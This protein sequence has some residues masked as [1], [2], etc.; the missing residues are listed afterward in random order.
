M[1]HLDPKTRA[2]DQPAEPTR[3]DKIASFMPEINLGLLLVSLGG[4]ALAA[5]VFNLHL[6]LQPLFTDSTSRTMHAF[7]TLWGH[8]APHLAAIG[9]VW[10]PLPTLVQIPMVIWKPLALTGLSG[11]LQSALSAAATATMLEALLRELK[12]GAALRWSLVIGYM[13]HPMVLLYAVNGMSESML[14]LTLVSSCFFLMR[15]AQHRR[16]WDLLLLSAAG[17]TAVLTRY[18]GLAIVAATA[19][20]IFV[21]SAHSRWPTM[22]IRVEGELLT[23]LAMP[24]YAVL[25]WLLFNGIIEGDPLYFFHSQYSAMAQGVYAPE[26]LRQLAHDP[27]LTT[28][29]VGWRVLLMA[30]MYLPVSALV[31]ILA[32]RRRDTLAP[33]LTLLPLSVLAFEWGA[34]YQGGQFGWFRFF[35]Y[36]VPG[37]AIAIGL[38]GRGCTR[39]SHLQP[40][41]MATLVTLMVAGNLVAGAAML[42]PD[43]GKEESRAFRA[44]LTLAPLHQEE[45]EEH[46][47]AD[48][49]RENI[50]GRRVLLD[51][52]AG[53]GIV[54][55]AGGSDLFV[56]TPDRDFA[57]VLSH[58]QGR[59]SHILVPKP[60]RVASL[61]AVNSR[62]PGLYDERWDFVELEREWPHWRLFRLR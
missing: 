44:L 23:Y 59:V 62:Y 54:R 8:E 58:P 21:I 60:E 27:W 31:L 46:H 2:T 55:S 14:I 41:A 43:V 13:A 49:L 10:M 53:I 39:P 50:T 30:P 32:L 35:M 4:Y 24:S 40:R 16:V 9:F 6:N 34:H 12:I 57:E 11:G 45:S 47:I 17:A 51:D 52:F 38:L 48:Y 36:A 29:F 22:R 33:A 5:A 26:Q 28:L 56:L 20:A 42:D 61:D 37:T 19:L 15:W 25:L 1:M 3:R 7:Y 18:E